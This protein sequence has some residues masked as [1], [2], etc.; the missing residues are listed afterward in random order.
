MLA[1]SYFSDAANRR[2]RRSGFVGGVCRESPELLSVCESGKS[3]VENC[4][5]VT[6]FVIRILDRQSLPRPFCSDHSR[7]ESPGYSM[8]PAVPEINRR[9]QE[10]VE[11]RRRH[12]ATEDHDRH[13]VL[14]FVSGAI[15]TQHDR[16]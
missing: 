13:R 10:E 4:G 3:I 16:H 6:E 1:Q 5:Q 12:Q 7:C 9:K 2:E 14:D 11:Y 8:S 15:S